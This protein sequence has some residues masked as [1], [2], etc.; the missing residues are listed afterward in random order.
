VPG[1]RPIRV[2]LAAVAVLGAAVALGLVLRPAAVSAA[3]VDPVPSDGSPLSVGVEVGGV[4]S[5]TG[6]P[7]V[8]RVTVGVEV[9]ADGVDAALT[10]ADGAARRV[11]AALR[12]ADVAP[13]D[14]Q[15]SNV[16]VS[17][18]YSDS[19]QRITGYTARHDLAVTLRDVGSAGAVLASV[20]DA[21]GDAARIEGV[22]YGLEDE[23]AV[24]RQARAAAFADAQRR[25][26]QYAELVGRELGDVLWVRENVSSPAPMPYAAAD[27]AAASGGSLALEPGTTTVTVTA[28][29]R[30]SL[31]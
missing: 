21:G 6:T 16:S 18:R 10:G 17:P 14:V 20:A 8:L 7:D 27:G 31:R 25:A 3:P 28:E 11:I 23:A 30:W 15:T 4:G 13:R 19:D 5:A 29:V 1:A 24:Q 9:V 26:E 12:D 2:P 22:S